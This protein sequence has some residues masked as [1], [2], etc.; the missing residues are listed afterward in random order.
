MLLKA[1]ALSLVLLV[2]SRLL[3]LAR[4]S[5][6]AGA[7]GT[8]GLGDVV[9]LML[10][11][12]DWLT[13]V[14]AS[15][16]LAYVLIPYWSGQPPAHHAGSQ[17]RVAISLLAGGIVLGVL[18]W[19][20]QDLAVQLLAPGI[21][22][23]LK[24]IASVAL[25]WSAVSLPLALLA[26][27][28]V[29][30]LQYERD[31][32]GMY[33]ANLVVNIVLVGALLALSQNSARVGA[34]GAASAVAHVGAWLLVAMVLRLIWLGWRQ[35]SQEPDATGGAD[36]IS[37]VNIIKAPPAPL[38]H[39]AIW[40]W[41][42]LSAGLP[43]VLPFVARS[44]ASQAGEGEL[45]T[46]N[47]AWKLLELPLILGV[48]LVAS[49][50]FPAI[51]RAFAGEGDPASTVR[52]SFALAWT[53]GCAAAAALLLMAPA[54]AQLLF[55]W[56]R[57]TPA[58][59]MRLS[60]WAAV[61]A[62]SLLPQSLIAV[63]LVVLATQGRMKPVVGAYA[64]GLAAL[65]LAAGWTGGDGARL[66]MVLNGVQVFVALA[67][68]MAV[69]PVARRWL[70]WRGMLAPFVLLLV[71]AGIRAMVGAAAWTLGPLAG[72]A[73]A[74]AIGFLVVAAGWTASIDVRRA[75]SR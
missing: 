2:A 42:A 72:L 29:T 55:G 71:A 26:A 57:M 54:L 35:H 11:L 19:L 48:Q 36:G 28:W 7:L 34:A 25:T 70:P 39:A 6:Q 10:T 5:A 45:A 58:S 20:A 47:Y 30:R 68:L 9:V 16:A 23:D 59:L 60:Q 49:L 31:F 1:G 22:P 4:E 74:G 66:M 38:P 63:S 65:C 40:L 52:Q 15:G 3:G 12:P 8:S 51:S 75:L 44:M 41:A 67:C 46:F 17:R 13:G 62:W 27:L 18:I 61:G 32:T 73:A 33:S 37:E 69:G 14:L 56:G 21:P 64:A 53:L 43:L 50:S 24:S